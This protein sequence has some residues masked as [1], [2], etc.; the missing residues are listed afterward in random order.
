MILSDPEHKVERLYAQVPPQHRAGVAVLVLDAMQRLASLDGA[1]LSV[2][3][4]RHRVDGH[5]RVAVTITAEGV[6]SQVMCHTP[7][8]EEAP[9]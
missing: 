2:V 6:V 5:Y 9:A 3:Q 4:G 8:I 1:V 7:F